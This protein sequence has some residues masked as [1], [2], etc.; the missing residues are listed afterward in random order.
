MDGNGQS[1]KY[2]D[3]IVLIPLTDISM[4]PVSRE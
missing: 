1:R 2:R 4:K 3:R